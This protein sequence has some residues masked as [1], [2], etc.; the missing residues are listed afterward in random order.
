MMKKTLIA[1]AAAALLLALPA[2]S[3]GCGDSAAAGSNN[4]TP[5][6]YNTI[7]VG[8]SSDQVK[9]IAGDPI[10]KETKSMHAGHSMGNGSVAGGSMTME[11]WYYQGNKGW[12]RL[13]VADGKVTAKSGY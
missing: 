11:Y 8:M 7:E 1:A 10:K 12:V 9:S 5:E 4:M 6:K 2:I 13:E 3:S